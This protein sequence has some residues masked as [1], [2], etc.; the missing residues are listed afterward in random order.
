M[1]ELNELQQAHEK[2]TKREMQTQAH[3]TACLI[4]AV[5]GSLSKDYEPITARHLTGEEPTEIERVDLDTAFA[6][7]ERV[8][9][10]R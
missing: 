8:K 10:G 7:L 6:E 5:L 4:N 2:K 9:R 3:F 1:R